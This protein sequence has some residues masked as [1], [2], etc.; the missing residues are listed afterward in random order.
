MENEHKV[1][2]KNMK[3]NHKINIRGLLPISISLML[4]L[5]ITF[6]TITYAWIFSTQFSDITGINVLLGESQGLIMAIN[7]NVS[8]SI[9]I[10]DY[11]GA[12]F[13]AFSLK[14]ASSSNGR[15][16]F[17]R[18]SG[19]Y[20]SDTENIYENISVARDEI[21]IIQFREAEITDQNTGFIYFN[22]TLQALGDNRYLIF[23]ALD[24]YIE[25]TNDQAIEPIR[26]S[27]TFIDGENVE[28]KIIGNRQEYYGNYSTE[29]VDSIDSITKVGYNGT[30]D[31]ETFSGYTGYNGEV[32]D[33]D[34]TLYCLQ[35]G[36]VIQLVI[37]I[38]LEG[39]DPLCTDSIAGSLLNIV[40]KFDNIAESEVV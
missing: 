13:S 33:E 28:T 16:L 15:D 17:L 14:E 38:W 8:Q 23:N 29:S 32:F 11:L 24:S 1:M 9:S 22:L 39:G 36:V 4:A 27:L 21:G 25:D 6:S 7:G 26:V 31:V 2:L 3:P 34:R 35:D 37:R 19:M 10:N 12:S 30:Q 5:M 40:L 20:Y 18:D